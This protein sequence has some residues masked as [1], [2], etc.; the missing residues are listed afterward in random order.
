MYLPAK[1]AQA[2]ATLALGLKS[3]DTCYKSSA[4]TTAATTA[5]F[6][7]TEPA[8][9]GFTLKNKKAFY[10]ASIAAAVGGGIAGAFG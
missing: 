8:V 4:I 10:M 2:G 1:Y 7:I 9:Y 5:V 3:K 6:G